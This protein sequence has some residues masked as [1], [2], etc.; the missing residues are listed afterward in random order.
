MMNVFE[1]PVMAKI[2]PKLERVSMISEA[3]SGCVLRQWRRE[4][5][6]CASLAAM[7]RPH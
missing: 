1:C 6:R 7:E 5:G 2:L 4:N 3:I